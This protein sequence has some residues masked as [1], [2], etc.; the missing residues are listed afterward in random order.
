MP[1]A[2]RN[3]HPVSGTWAVS[4]LEKLAL[5]PRQRPKNSDSAFVVSLGKKN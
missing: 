4:P 2:N 3:A 5:N 1:T